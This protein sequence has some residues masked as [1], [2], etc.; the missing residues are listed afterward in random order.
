VRGPGAA[1]RAIRNTLRLV[2]W[3][4]VGF[5]VG[6]ALALA[7]PF[8]FDARPLAVLSGSMEPQLH[9]GDITVVERIQPMDAR[10]GDIVTFQDPAHPRLVTHRVRN[11]QV[12]GD[13]VIFTTRGD[14][15]NLS[16]RWQVKKA[17]EIS[18]AMYTVPKLG[19]ALIY[20]RNSG[21]LVIGFGVLLAALL[22]LELSSIWRDEDDPQVAEESDEALA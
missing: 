14:A 22:V 12:K 2:G 6:I 7:L 21:I 3:T 10:K 4:M 18:R 9:V 13:Q 19:H 17:G 20:A 11:M 5:C 16:E 8:A 15:N 1:G